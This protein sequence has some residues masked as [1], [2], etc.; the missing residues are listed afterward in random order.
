M[1]QRNLKVLFYINFVDFIGVE[2]WMSSFASYMNDRIWLAL[3]IA[4][5]VFDFVFIGI[6]LCN[7][8]FEWVSIKQFIEWKN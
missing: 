6:E 5:Y 8:V 3:K 7:D 4:S 2:T 1:K